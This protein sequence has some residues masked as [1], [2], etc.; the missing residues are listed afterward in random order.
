MPLCSIFACPFAGVL[1]RAFLYFSWT[2]YHASRGLSFLSC[3]LCMLSVREF[4]FCLTHGGQTLQ[5]RCHGAPLRVSR[6]FV[7]FVRSF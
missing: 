2:K 3:D 4:L 6:A 7:C 1:G 5:G